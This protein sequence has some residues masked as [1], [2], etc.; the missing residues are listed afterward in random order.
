MEKNFDILATYP[1]FLIDAH[2]FHYGTERAVNVILWFVCC[3]FS[4]NL[5]CLLHG[6]FYTLFLLE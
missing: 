3:L 1:L 4:R 6:Y 5:S 2:V